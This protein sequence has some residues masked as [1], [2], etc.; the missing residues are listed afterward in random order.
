MSRNVFAQ[1]LRE[2]LLETKQLAHVGN[3]PNKPITNDKT[4]PLGFQK[5]GHENRQ[6][7]VTWLGHHVVPLGMGKSQFQHMLLHLE[8]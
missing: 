7:G 6:H 2:C 1:Y 5:V 3:P 4:K 8:K